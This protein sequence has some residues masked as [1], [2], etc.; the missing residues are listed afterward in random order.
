MAV[1]YNADAIDRA[2]RMLVKVWTQ[3]EPD[4]K[5]V[6]AFSAAQK[7]ASKPNPLQ[8]VKLPE[9]D[10]AA[11]QGRLA[12]LPAGSDGAPDRVIFLISGNRLADAMREAQTLLKNPNTA[13]KGAL[14]AARVFKAADLNLL[15]A[16][17]FLKYLQKPTGDDPIAAFLQ[18]QAK[19]GAQQ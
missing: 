10:A 14:E 5:G 11:L 19:T 2:S 18:N 9:V 7:D 15:G 12:S 1:P 3:I 8:E 13:E 4:K 16:N 17:A 6:T